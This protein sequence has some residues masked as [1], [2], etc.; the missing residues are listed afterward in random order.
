MKTRAEEPELELFR[1]SL[2]NLDKKESASCE[3]CRL[4]RKVRPLS[5]TLTASR[6]RAASRQACESWVRAAHPRPARFRPASAFRHIVDQ[7]IYML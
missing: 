2:M 1:T 5:Q 3:V 7:N 4:W 6:R